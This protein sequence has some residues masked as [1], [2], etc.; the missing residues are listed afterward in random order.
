MSKT[1]KTI[2]KKVLYCST[3]CQRVLGWCCW[4]IWSCGWWQRCVSLADLTA[5][6]CRHRTI[7]RSQP[8]GRQV[9]ERWV[10]CMDCR[11]S[12]R[13]Q[14]AYNKM[15]DK[16]CLMVET[17]LQPLTFMSRYYWRIWCTI[18]DSCQSINQSLFSVGFKN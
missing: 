17:C 9:L 5:A 10:D 14:D 1:W 16:A 4:Q 3:W 2:I 6:V 7:D 11:C 12:G 13:E 15:T 8:T 18:T